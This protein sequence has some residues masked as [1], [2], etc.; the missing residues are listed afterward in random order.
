MV[1]PSC[2]GSGIVSRMDNLIGDAEDDCKKEVRW[3][4]PMNFKI[5]PLINKCEDILSQPTCS[6]IYVPL[7]MVQNF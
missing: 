1:D 3:V 4:L 5:I 7:D 2:S 6:L